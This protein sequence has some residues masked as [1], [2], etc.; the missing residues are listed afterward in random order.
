MVVL[1]SLSAVTA[2]ASHLLVRRYLLASILGAVAASVLFQVR[3]F[4]NR[5]YLDMFAP[6]AFVCG[7]GVAF[8]VALI[9]GLPI[10]QMRIG[11]S[12]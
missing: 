10:R 11:K 9:V 12:K 7:G 4:V 6:V 5:G 8:V 3:D 2:I 1:T